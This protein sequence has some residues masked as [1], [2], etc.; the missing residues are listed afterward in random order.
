MPKGSPIRLY[1]KVKCLSAEVRNESLHYWIQ[2]HSDCSKIQWDKSRRLLPGS[3]VLLTKN[4][5]SFDSVVF[6]IVGF[7]N[8]DDLKKH[9]Q[10]TIIP[11]NSTSCNVDMLCDDT[12]LVLIESEVYWESFR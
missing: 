7:R 11:E 2:L 4:S 10:F 5:A 8:D 3:L 9:R 6:A 12:D 1:Y